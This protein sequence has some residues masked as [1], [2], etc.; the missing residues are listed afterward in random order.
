ME[1]AE[2]TPEFDLSL[3]RVR[4]IESDER[5]RWDALMRAHHYLEMT[6]MVGRSLRY[7]AHLDGHWLALLGPGLASA[8]S[9]KPR[10]L[11]R[12]GAHAAM[13]AIGLDR[14]PQPLSDFAQFA[15]AI[16]S[17]NWHAR[18]NSEPRSP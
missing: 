13:A 5:A 18:K 12:L 15:A 7:V 8:Q 14:K 10:R 1:A 4:L 6:A 16:E 2:P 3:V 11:D 17:A 9:G